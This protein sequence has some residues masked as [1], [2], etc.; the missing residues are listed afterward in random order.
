M[1]Q[2]I[3]N[4]ELVPTQTENYKVSEKKAVEELQNLDAN[5]ESLNKWKA[6]LGLGQVK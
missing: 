4:D 2:Q 5:D 3:E 6:T 1:S